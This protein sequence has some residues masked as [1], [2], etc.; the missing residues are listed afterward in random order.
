[1]ARSFD[2]RFDDWGVTGCAVES[3]LDSKYLRVMR[4]LIEKV[5]DGLEAFVWVVQKDVFGRDLFKDALRVFQLF[6]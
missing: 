4:R 1:M 6:W 5:D 3:L 2:K